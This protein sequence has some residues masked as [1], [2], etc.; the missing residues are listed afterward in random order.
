MCDCRRGWLDGW[1]DVMNVMLQ[2]QVQ[3]RE[4]WLKLCLILPDTSLKHAGYAS[5]CPLWRKKVTGQHPDTAE[6]SPPTRLSKGLSQA[7]VSVRD[8]QPH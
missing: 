4:S 2:V 5:A 1:M 3:R 8:A 6:E 7:T